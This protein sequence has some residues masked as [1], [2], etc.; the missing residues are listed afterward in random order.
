[1]IHPKSEVHET[2]VIGEGCKVWQFA[3]VG[4]RTVIEDDCVIGSGA[5][6]GADCRIGR[7]ARIQH[8]AFLPNG[9]VIEEHVFIGPNVTATDDRYPRAGNTSY[10]RE[11]P[12]IC[13][14]ASI[15]AGA[16][17]LPGVVIGPGAMVAAGAV[18]TKNVIADLWVA[19]LPAREFTK[20]AL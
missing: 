9:T 12:R 6:I 10:T 20:R 7:G 15:G 3:S 1:M 18:V 14:G 5:W 4:A 17:I 16:V 19:G 2:A 8:G 11:P 13:H